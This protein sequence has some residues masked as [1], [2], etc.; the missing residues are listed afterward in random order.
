MLLQGGLLPSYFY[1]FSLFLL[2]FDF[3][4]APEMEGIHNCGF[5]EKLPNIDTQADDAGNDHLHV[6][7][8]FISPCQLLCH[9]PHSQLGDEEIPTSP[10]TSSETATR[11]N[12]CVLF[13]RTS[14]EYRDPH[15]G[16]KRHLTIV[17][18]GE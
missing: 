17:K 5:K 6:G 9:F 18:R 13:C 14:L 10:D 12:L 3:R 2:R 16:S 1:C 8:S 4:N 11:I 15:A 7:Y